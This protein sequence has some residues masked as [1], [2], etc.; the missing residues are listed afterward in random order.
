MD[1]S[2]LSQPWLVNSL[3]SRVDHERRFLAKVERSLTRLQRAWKEI[4][5]QRQAIVTIQAFWRGTLVRL[6]PPI[7]L[8][9]FFE[10]DTWV[11]CLHTNRL[12]ARSADY[13]STILQ[14]ED[15]G[16][17]KPSPFFDQSRFSRCL[18]LA[19]T[20]KFKSEKEVVVFLD[21][22]LCDTPI[23]LALYDFETWATFYDFLDFIAAEAKLESLKALMKKTI[24]PQEEGAPQKKT[25]SLT[26]VEASFLDQWVTALQLFDSIDLAPLDSLTYL[27][28]ISR[29]CLP[30][31]RFMEGLASISPSKVMVMDDPETLDMTLCALAI[32]QHFAIFDLETCFPR[33]CGTDGTVDPD[34]DKL[35]EEFS[36]ATANRTI[37]H[38]VL[39]DPFTLTSCL[40][41]RLRPPEVVAAA[42]HKDTS[43]WLKPLL[44]STGMIWGKEIGILGGAP[45][46]WALG[47]DDHP[48]DIDIFIA[49]EALAPIAIQAIVDALLPHGPVVMAI[50]EA[51]LTIR[52]LVPSPPPPIQIILSSSTTVVEALYNFDYDY[53]QAMMF[54]DGSLKCTALAFRAWRNGIANLACLPLEGRLIS[55]DTLVEDKETLWLPEAKVS[56]YRAL[57]AISKGFDLQP[58]LLKT[59][60]D[61]EQ[62][63]AKIRLAPRPPLPVDDPYGASALMAMF[64]ARTLHT[65]HSRLQSPED[66]AGYLENVNAAWSFSRPNLH[67]DV[68]PYAVDGIDQV[69]PAA[70]DPFD[71]SSISDVEALAL[72]IYKKVY[73]LKKSLERRLKSRRRGLHGDWE[74]LDVDFEIKGRIVHK[75]NL[76]N[77]PMP[78]FGKIIIGVPR[79]SPSGRLLHA[80]GINTPLNHKDY[81]DHFALRVYLKKD[82]LLA[83]RETP[84]GCTQTG[85]WPL[86]W[87][88]RL[89]VSAVCIGSGH[90]AQH[91]A[92]RQLYSK[93]A[94]FGQRNY[95]SSFL[96]GVQSTKSYIYPTHYP[97]P[98]HKRLH[99]LTGLPQETVSPSGKKWVKKPKRIHFDSGS[100]TSS[101]DTDSSD[102]EP[103]LISPP[104]TP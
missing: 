47:L 91:L 79:T 14:A 5:R 78:P 76:P 68:S 85:Q 20:R 46:C 11:T 2:G 13:F 38:Q 45:V 4:Y 77:D 60:T 41:D 21:F 61:S 88:I 86:G 82:P 90:Y 69:D 17:P 19:T 93:C 53:V 97:G 15:K 84:S 83:P 74:N 22:L 6:W 96:F 35:I 1:S 43:L 40:P 39:I 92:P 57:K 70:T 16:F 42:F 29:S 32:I 48:Y 31:D 50:S 49:K 23:P 58:R 56:A 72:K 94:T 24:L 33:H 27:L 18:H 12:L 34:T 101:S 99:L 67:S 102:E 87:I 89:G 9:G 36:G 100:E 103:F 66:L 37:P 3:A 26:I 81:P 80:L 104:A 75:T 28:E 73:R 98:K 95:N 55:S 7:G 71:F 59:F 44:H 30:L 8:T 63:A 64:Y 10:E 25:G 65:W 51:F 62:L 52:L 54:P